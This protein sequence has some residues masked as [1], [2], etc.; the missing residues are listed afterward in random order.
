MTT[1]RKCIVPDLLR[2]VRMHHSDDLT[3][4]H[5]GYATPTL[6]CG[7]HATYY[8]PEVAEARKAEEV[9]S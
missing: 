2:G 9:A 3:E 6:V 1:H 4:V 5:H 8:M 7:F